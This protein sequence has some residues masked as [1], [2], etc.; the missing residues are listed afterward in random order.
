MSEESS[1]YAAPAQTVVDVP[2]MPAETLS[3]LQRSLNHLADHLDNQLTFSRSTGIRVPLTNKLNAETV[4]AYKKWIKLMWMAQRISHN[5]RSPFVGTTE[6]NTGDARGYIPLLSS[7]IMDLS[8]G[9]FDKFYAGDS[10]IAV[11]RFSSKMLNQMANSLPNSR[12]YAPKGASVD[13]MDRL[14]AAYDTLQDSGWTTGKDYRGRT[15]APP[16]PL[17]G[18]PPNSVAQIIGLNKRI[19]Y[20]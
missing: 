1:S 16:V 9:S 3:V 14:E 5:A 10:S 6:V 19:R 18:S 12:G 15:V 20:V 13:D 8:E 11:A 2:Q 7:S 4:A 17:L